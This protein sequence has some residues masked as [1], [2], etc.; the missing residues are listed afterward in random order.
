MFRVLT[1][2]IC[3]QGNAFARS[4]A[5]FSFSFRFVEGKF[6]NQFFQIN[7]HFLDKTAIGVQTPKQNL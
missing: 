3:Q 6:A 5:F 4:V 7:G 2:N 1:R